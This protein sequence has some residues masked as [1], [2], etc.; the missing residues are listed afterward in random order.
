MSV[1]SQV[2][3]SA[4]HQTSA[5]RSQGSSTTSLIRMTAKPAAMANAAPKIVARSCPSSI[6]IRA[7]S[8]IARV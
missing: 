8:T 2:S 6:E 5:S 1:Q 7:I 4:A 3:L